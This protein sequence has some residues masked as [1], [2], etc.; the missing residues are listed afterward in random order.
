MYSRTGYLIIELD[1]VGPTRDVIQNTCDNKQEDY[2]R[3]ERTNVVDYLKF[4][5]W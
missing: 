3:H 4:K 2:L 1:H 5:K